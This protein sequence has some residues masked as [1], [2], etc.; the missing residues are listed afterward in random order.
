MKLCFTIFIFLGITNLY[1]DSLSMR[2]CMLLPVDDSLKDSISF[3]VYEEVEMYLKE[4][5]WCYFRSNSGILNILD[6]YKS[7]LNTHLKN[8]KILNLLAKKMGVGS[9][10][11]ISMTPEVKGVELLLEIIGEDGEDKYFIKKSLIDSPTAQLL[12]QNV[13][14]WLEEYEKVIPYNARIIGVIGDQFTIDMGKDIGILPGD[15]VIIKRPVKKKKHPLLKEIVDWET[16]KIGQGKIFHSDRTQSHGK[17]Y[18]YSSNS[19]LQNFD[20]IELIKKREVNQKFIESPEDDEYKFGRVGTVSA[21]L[22]LG[23][24]SVTTTT[25]GSTAAKLGG[26]SYGIDLKS[27]LWI[28]RNIF[29]GLDYNTKI[30]TYSLKSGNATNQESDISTG[31]VKMKFGYKYLPLGFFY[32]PQVDI[33]LGYGRY[34]YGLDD[35]A[36]SI[37]SCTFSGLLMGVGASLPINNYFKAFLNID[38][39]F[40]PGYTEDITL[41]GEADSATNFNIEL[42]GSFKFSQNIWIDGV[43]GANNSKAKFVSPSERSISYQDS[44]FKLGATFSF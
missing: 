6:K 14:K 29:L 3:K 8:P 39:M 2:R 11:K 35:V 44:S 9:L 7:N 27:Q 21:L 38:F 40:N 41:Y 43:I 18:E 34:S 4:S 5:N 37:V 12:A 24:G 30:S 25:S 20:W 31:Q 1:A 36:D 26:F 19:S 33:I 42:G 10:I 15:E 32:G 28:T 17:V 23:S 22:D 16:R 13:K